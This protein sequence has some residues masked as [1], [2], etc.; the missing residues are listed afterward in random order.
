MSRGAGNF[1]IS[2]K[3]CPSCLRTPR[4]KRLQ[5]PI[6]LL[7]SVSKQAHFGAALANLVA[8]L[9]A[10]RARPCPANLAAADPPGAAHVFGHL[11]AGKS[12]VGA[13]PVGEVNAV[14]KLT[15]GE[16]LAQRL[17][18]DGLRGLGCA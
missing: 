17:A 18:A 8:L 16:Q 2:P 15:L 6:P 7:G 11:R 14:G 13:E 1:F 10:A 12:S 3:P 9:R 4:L 5:G